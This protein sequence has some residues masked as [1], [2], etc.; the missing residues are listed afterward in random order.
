MLSHN[1]IL[2][3]QVR[4]FAQFSYPFPRGALYI[5]HSDGLAARWDLGAYPGLE[6]RHPALIAA[7]LF[8]DYER[9]RDDA[10]VVAVR[11]PAQPP[12]ES[13]ARQ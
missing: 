12:P 8:R 10:T 7:V 9:G 13:Q 3:H 11:N 1:G 6:S 5:A 4:K 2:G